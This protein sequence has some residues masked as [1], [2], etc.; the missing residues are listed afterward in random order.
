MALPANYADAWWLLKDDPKVII[1]EL[2]DGEGT[3]VGYRKRNLFTVVMGRAVFNITSFR[4]EIGEVR[5]SFNVTTGPTTQ[6][7][8]AYTGKKFI[9]TEN[10]REL[11]DPKTGTYEEKQTWVHKSE[12]EEIGPEGFTD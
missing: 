2:R 3:L 6:I 11:V 4:S 5:S 9:C 10:T 1:E 12:G 7:A 8:V